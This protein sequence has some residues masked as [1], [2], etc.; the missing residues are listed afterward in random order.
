VD[1]VSAAV[2]TAGTQLTLSGTQFD[3]AAVNDALGVSDTRAVISAA[4]SS[5]LTWTVPASAGSGAIRVATPHGQV[6]GPD[7]YIPPPGYSASSV[8]QATRMT[9]GGSQQV[10]VGTSGGI[11]MLIFNATAGQQLFVSLTSSSFSGGSIQLYDPNNT[12]FTNDFLGGY[13]D[14]TPLPANGTYTLLLAPSTTGQATVTLSDVPADAPYSVSPSQAGA[15]VSVATGTPGQNASVT[16]AASQGQRVFVQPSNWAYTGGSGCLL[17]VTVT[18]PGASTLSGPRI[19]CGNSDSFDMGEAVL[20]QTGT[21]TFAVDPQGAATGSVTLTFYLLPADAPFSVTPSQAGAAV[22]VAT[23]TPGQNASV[24]FAAS[25]GQRVFVQPSNWAYTGGSGCL[26]DVTVTNPD[27]STF[28]GPSIWCDNSSSFD[29]G[30]TTLPQTGTYTLAVDPQGAAAGSVTL[31]FYLLPADYSAPISIGGAPVTVTTT[32]PGQNAALTFT[33]TAAQNIQLSASNVT[34]PS[35]RVSILNPDGSTLTS[36]FA[37]GGGPVLSATLGTA[38]TY[39]VF[40]DPQATATG[41]MTLTLTDPPATPATMTGRAQLDALAKRLHALTP[42]GSALSSLAAR[43]PAPAGG[44]GQP[45][46]GRARVSRPRFHTPAAASWSPTWRNRR[47]DW[48]TSQV[49]SP[50]AKLPP[51]PVP[52]GVTAVAGRVLRLNGMPLAGVRLTLEG[53]SLTTHT[54]S[55][56]RFALTGVL[57]GHHVLDVNTPGPGRPAARYATFEIGVDA[58]KG[59]ENALPYTIWLPRLDPAHAVAVASP[60]RH[61][62]TLTTPRIPGLQ[63]RIP[64][65]STI[66]GPGGQPVKHLSIIP[67]PVDRPP[68]PLPMGSFFPVYLSV[69]PAGAYVSGGA[70]II[71]PNYSHLPPGQKVPFWNYDPG[72][73]S[74]YIYGEG[75]VS[76]SG[77]RI[78]PGPGV[79]VW[80]FTGA[81]ISGSVP[82]PKPPVPCGASAADPVDLGSGLF[83]YQKTDLTLPGILPVQLTRVYRPADA[84]SYSFG[85]G[86]TSTY[87]MRLFSQNIYQ[88][89]ELILPDG[90]DIHYARISPGTGMEDAVFQA[91]N[92]CTQY[93][94]SVIRWNANDNGWDLR[95][96][97]GL[98]YVFAMDAEFGLSAI[99]DRFG[100][101][102]TLTRDSAGN[103]TQVTGPGG[104]WITFQHDARNRIT[105]ATDNMGRTVTY[106]YNPA[107]DLA[108]AADAAGN[109]PTT[110]TYD[111][112]TGWMTQ[113]TDARGN[114]FLTNAYDTNGRIVQ[115][116]LGNQ[117]QSY[118]FGYTL[119]GSGQVT[120]T[121]MTTPDGRQTTESFNGD[122]Y[123]T[124]ITRGAG[125]PQ[126]QTTSYQYQPG[127]DLLTSDTDQLGRT[128][129]FGY[130]VLGNLNSITPMAGTPGA[131]TTTIV[132]DPQFSQP[133]KVTSPLSKF[134]LYGY[135]SKG[136]LTSV[137]DP[138]NNQTVIAYANKNGLPTSVTDPLHNTTSLSYFLGDAVAV[139]GP[140][141]DTSVSHFDGA[142]RLLSHTDPLGD[143][144]S[145][146]YDPLNDLTSITDAD[147]NGTTF[148]YDADQDL[149]LLTDPATSKTHY[150]YSSL[151]RLTSRQDALGN[152]WIYGYDNEGDLTSAQTPAGQSTTYHYDPL[153]R[154]DFAGYTPAGGSGYQSTVNYTYDAGDRL[155][156]ADDSA[157]GTFHQAWD[158]FN[159]LTQQDGPN[160]TISYSYDAAGNQLTATVS[161][162]PA[163]SYGY[164]DDGNLASVS[165]N[166]Q[167]VTLSYDTAGRPQA[168]TL[169]DGITENY[170]YDPAS[171]L[172]GISYTSGP[173]TLGTLAYAY[174]PAG[175][176]TAEWGSYA[177]LAIPAASGPNT[178]NADNA[179]TSSGATSYGYD[180]DGNMT[181]D[182]S[183]TYS[184]NARDQLTSITGPVPAS[185][186]YD[187]FGR[188]EQATIN[189]A[190][191]SYLYDGPNA[192]QELVGGSPAANYLLGPELGQRYARTDASGT[193]SYLTDALGSVIALAGSAATIQ[194]TYTYD[195]FGSAA[196][197]GA[198]S[199]NPFQYAGAQSDAT[200]L[201]YDLARYYSPGLGRFTRQDPAGL[202][203]SG[204][205]LYQ[206]AND[207]PIG[208][209][210]PSGLSSAKNACSLPGLGWPDPAG[211]G[212]L[213]AGGALTWYQTFGKGLHRVGRPHYLQENPWAGKAAGFGRG[214]IPYGLGIAGIGVGAGLDFLT[215][216]GQCDSP[217]EALLKS[218]IAGG[219]SAGLGIAGSQLG[220]AGGAFLGA[221]VPGLGETGISEAAGAA[222][223]AFLGGWIGN[224]ISSCLLNSLL[225]P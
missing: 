17:D 193:H 183:S 203:G 119:N 171:N 160:G 59:L 210:D 57:A 24:T 174:D 182:G 34:I 28:S 77:K 117:T 23:G 10:T 110:Y 222:L 15:A 101:K 42:V 163:G 83:I 223:G 181:S 172:T 168:T 133:T 176:I 205:N 71:Y 162:Q 30:E 128:T 213:G 27:H 46:P 187:P 149:T 217:A 131:R 142:G 188:R 64:A 140:N 156:Q 177:S 134:T 224:M 88:T 44:P 81:M 198:A 79:R 20:P 65:G 132:Y 218:S 85:T 137:T 104:R 48:N 26:L 111:P 139:T 209:S 212:A 147:G 157:G 154:L 123:P 115:Q 9:L 175:N 141:G 22:S 12:Q 56:G 173:T 191:T 73:R 61:A 186:T 100:N 113:I 60:L 148:A 19:W 129:T 70:Q 55:T 75:T 105:S 50:W 194:T 122:G 127:T 5:S 215:F 200:G 13:I 143:T 43:H 67:V 195:P 2:A 62:L 185:F 208:F 74:W 124:S 190:T 102:V 99:R 92:T 82:P 97:T 98:T 179:L 106:T 21:Y 36:S 112:G 45:A 18:S 184:W 51:L 68:F 197:S 164:D 153:R 152:E 69:Q 1:S 32:T 189:S 25:Q 225:G 76:G 86:T 114:V 150:G 199:S 38:G 151:D 66:T 35:S 196:S 180:L 16:F 103:L 118:T 135:D 33:G 220:E 120:Q 37:F 84:N 40:V 155:T 121:T 214:G 178:Y 4:T 94:A 169:P 3:T 201:Q 211:N 89:T 138:L 14:T 72:K 146:G 116:T 202:A 95:L 167:H 126:A 145:Y 136:E 41:S 207:N 219:Y 11:A 31:T 170:S 87:D 8:V 130:D 54:D 53:T 63:V 39:T 221:A 159:E 206:Y 78:I 7:L 144:T 108:T 6:T 165:Q 158:G 47:G 90:E 49:S 91:Q 52:V 216:T 125:T 80:E 192:V 107:G 109:P 93:Y 58:R 29:M 96:R 204:P 161:G 166:G